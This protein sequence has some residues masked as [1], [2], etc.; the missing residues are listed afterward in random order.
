MLVGLRRSFALYNQEF[1]RPSLELMEYMAGEYKTRFGGRVHPLIYLH[2]A[3]TLINLNHSDE[4]KTYIDLLLGQDPDFIPAQAYA[5]RLEDDRAKAAE[6]LTKLKAEHP[7][8]WI[9]KQL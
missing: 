1:M 5:Y 2:T 3:E 8:H 6:R 9:V 7:N 4:A